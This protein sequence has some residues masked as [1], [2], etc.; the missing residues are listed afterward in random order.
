MRLN[1]KN[2]LS[3]KRREREIMSKEAR[4][5]DLIP[6]LKSA[7]EMGY[8]T[9]LS[10][11]HGIGKT[12]A[13]MQAVEDLNWRMK[14]YSTSTLDPY[15]DLVG[16]P[17]PTAL[18]GD[19]P[20]LKMVRPQEINE[21]DLIFFDE[22]NR[23]DPRTLNAVLEIVQF[24]S[25][26]GEHLPNLKCVVGA[27]NPSGEDYNVDDLDPALLD[28]F[29]LYYDLTPKSP[30]AYLLTKYP[31]N[32]V[33]AF[34]SWWSNHNTAKREEYISPRRLDMMMDIYTKTGSLDLL[35]HAIHDTIEV[36]FQALK[37]RIAVAE[38][39]AKPGANLKEKMVKADWWTKDTVSRNVPDVAEYIVN[40]PNDPFVVDNA[41][42]FIKETRIGAEALALEYGEILLAIHKAN[43]SK[44]DDWKTKWG[45]SKISQTRSFLR[46][47]AQSDEDYKEI[48]KAM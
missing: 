46:Q 48:S 29:H 6:S 27:V 40:N 18:E 41:S 47:R 33:D 23:A 30:R 31:R 12:Y 28:R 2:V 26:N 9:L 21:V 14:Y 11:V 5:T 3:N 24:H 35:E 7:I 19:N 43:P 1:S 38:G 10:G 15:V 34:S 36:D 4:K 32:L 22:L 39:K 37:D 25:I 13:V 42:E 45:K 17:V 44:I 8:N 20:I 16:V